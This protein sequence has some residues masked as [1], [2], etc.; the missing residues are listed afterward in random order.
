MRF[1][2]VILALL[3][4]L[5]GVHANVANK[6]AMD[7][8]PI[9]LQA[10]DSLTV[11][12]DILELARENAF[13]LISEL[14]PN[15]V[16]TV[17]EKGQVISQKGA[18]QK[19]ST[20]AVKKE[21]KKAAA[22]KE[23]GPKKRDPN[24]NSKVRVSSLEAKLAD[25]DSRKGKSIRR[26]CLGDLAKV[27]TARD[28]LQH[29]SKT[30]NAAKAKHAKNAAIAAK[31]IKDMHVAEKVIATTQTHA[32][33][34]YRVKKA[35]ANKKDLESKPKNGFDLWQEYHGVKERK[36][37][38]DAIAILN[39]VELDAQI[40]VDA[41]AE[42]EAEA[43]VEADVEAEVE[44]EA[45][46]EAEAE[47]EAEAENG[48]DDDDG[49]EKKREPVLS[50]EERDRRD[51]EL[52]LNAL[53]ANLKPWRKS[54]FA[55]QVGGATIPWALTKD[56]VPPSSAPVAFPKRKFVRA[57]ISNPNFPD[58]IDAEARKKAYSKLKLPAKTS[59][60]KAILAESVKVGQVADKKHA[61]FVYGPIGQV[62]IPKIVSPIIT[63]D[64]NVPNF[65][66]DFPKPCLKPADD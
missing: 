49:T 52:Y 28:N 4:V 3:G 35:Y 13:K 55:N 40:S 62:M 48:A 42:G 30:V 12:E 15:A 44:G 54:R 43:D 60:D 45:S 47:A 17:D 53:A 6:A 10:E 51:E 41:D 7:N 46:M 1:A 22:K 16:Q 20:T 65:L 5:V 36:I 66:H 24:D 23:A 34:I 19:S 39:E 25:A 64:P 32:H 27:Y 8:E 56:Q 57:I 61:E 21:E 29:M 18:A 11:T 2:L 59:F 14:V 37:K 50:Q 9:M 26:R 33:N 38:K 31:V 63:K 58:M